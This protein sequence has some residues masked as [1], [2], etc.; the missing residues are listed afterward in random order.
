[1]KTCRICGSQAFAVSPSA[2]LS[3]GT[4]RQPRIVCLLR[5][6]NLLK[7]LLQ[8]AALDPVAGKEDQAAAVFAGAGQGN[9]QLLAGFPQEGVRQLHQHAGA[10]ACVH[11]SDPGAAAVVEVLQDLDG[12]A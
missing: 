10:V 12:S 2:E 5:L 6:D 8:L 11:V 4:V 3:T 9:P 1:M 7:A